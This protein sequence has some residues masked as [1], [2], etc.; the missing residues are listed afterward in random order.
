MMAE[1]AGARISQAVILAGGR[2]TR[3]GALTDDTPKPMVEVAGRPFLDHL[4]EEVARHGLARITLLCGYLAETIAER[5]DGRRIRDTLVECL[6]EP[7]PLGTGGALVNAASR[8]DERFLMMNGDTFFDINLLDLA[9]RF[10][11]GHGLGMMAL[12]GAPPGQRFGSVEWDGDRVTGFAPRGTA[13]L[14]NGG[15]YALD[16]RVLDLVVGLPCSI[17]ADI[18]PELARAGELRGALYDRFFVDIGVPQSLREA[19]TSI[20]AQRRRPAVFFDRDGVL[21]RDIGYLHRAEAWEWIDGARA[22]VK[23]LNDRGYYVFV[24]TN[25]AGV[26]RGLYGEQDIRALHGWVNAE[27]AREGA[28]IDAFYYCPHHPEGVVAAYR[29]LCECRK[30]GAQ[31]LR[32]A[33]AEWPVDVGASLL[34][35]DRQSDLDAAAAAGIRAV[36]FDGSEPLDLFL[37]GALGERAFT[38]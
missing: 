37:A 5:Y 27:L 16:R 24:V 19:H 21:N 33:L 8:L 3:L 6:A 10:Q 12:R 28:H 7:T 34:V 9:A 35:G 17:E 4:L 32:D 1:P 36:L 22:A 2:G 31:M 13:P 30:P 25:Q 23:S 18:F 20:S 26:A 38:T 11:E 29:T 15:V 14:I